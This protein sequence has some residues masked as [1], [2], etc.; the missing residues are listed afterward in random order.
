MYRYTN[1]KEKPE[2]PLSSESI[3]PANYSLCMVFDGAL[4]LDWKI[5]LDQAISETYFDIESNAG[6]DDSIEGKNHFIKLFLCFCKRKISFHTEFLGMAIVEHCNEDS[7]E[8][9]QDIL[10]LFRVTEIPI[11]PCDTERRLKVKKTIKIGDLK[12][13]FMDAFGVGDPEENKH[14]VMNYETSKSCGINT[15]TVRLNEEATLQVWFS[16]EIGV[17]H[18][19]V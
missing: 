12:K 5:N 2:N 15:K 8:T 4:D 6:Q 3:T 16:M 11:R 10:V 18:T 14:F 19:P 1:G 7:E 17:S 13:Q 9:N